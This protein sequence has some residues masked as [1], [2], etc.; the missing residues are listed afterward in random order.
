VIN[1]L[2]VDGQVIG[3]V[4]HGIGNTFLERVK[5][6]EEGQ[7]LTGT[8]ADYL[9]PTTM[10][11]PK[12]DLGYVATPCPL[13]PLGMKGAG[14]GGTIPVAAVLSA[15]V[16]NALEPLGVRLAHVPFS[17]SELLGMIQSKGAQQ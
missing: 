7:I 11:M 5:Y 1:P 15:A 13:N 9:M 8:F 4:A 16:E 12:I 10:D 6:D 14:Q 2:I 17:E 3:G